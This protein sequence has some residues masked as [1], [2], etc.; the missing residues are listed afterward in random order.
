MFFQSAASL[1]KAVNVQVGDSA[2]LS[3][4]VINNPRGQAHL[5]RYLCTANNTLGTN[6]KTLQLRGVPTKY[7]TDYKR[8]LYSKLAVLQME[9]SFSL[10]KYCICIYSIQFLLTM[11]TMKLQIAKNLL[12]GAKKGSKGFILL[13]FK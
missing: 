3:V 7:T 2:G 13:K 10:K 6:S 4:V 5:G 12:K 11:E 1:T 8:I 9:N